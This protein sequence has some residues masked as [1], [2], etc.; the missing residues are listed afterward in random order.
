MVPHLVVPQGR[1][2]LNCRKNPVPARLRMFSTQVIMH[3]VNDSTREKIPYLLGRY[4]NLAALITIV[5]SVYPGHFI[6]ILSHLV[7]SLQHIYSTLKQPLSPS[8]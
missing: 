6:N 7:S 2:R 8:S 3:D 1:I 4:A 5:V